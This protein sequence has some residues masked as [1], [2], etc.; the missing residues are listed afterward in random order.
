MRSYNRTSSFL[1]ETIRTSKMKG[2]KHGEKS[3]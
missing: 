2:A 1:L 3:I